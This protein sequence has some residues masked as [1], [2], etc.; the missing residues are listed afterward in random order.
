MLIPINTRKKHICVRSWEE[1]WFNSF[2][3]KP[4]YGCGTYQ[5]DVVHSSLQALETRVEE[6]CRPLHVPPARRARER[7]GGETEGPRGNAHAAHAEAANAR[8]GSS[9][10]HLRTYHSLNAL[11]GSHLRP[12]Y[13]NVVDNRLNRLWI[14][15]ALFCRLQNTNLYI[16]SGRLRMHSVYIV[17]R[18][19]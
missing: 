6:G 18:V 4:W 7:D 19:S 16:Y 9:D 12:L 10:Q 13:I 8:A 15:H 11:Q 17:G 1:S 2:P 14:A 5:A 3:T